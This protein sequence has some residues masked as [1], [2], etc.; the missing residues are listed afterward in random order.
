VVNM[1]V[2][3]MDSKK[4][5]SS[6]KTEWLQYI[7]TKYTPNPMNQQVDMFLRNKCLEWIHKTGNTKRDIT[8]KKVVHLY[9]NQ[10]MQLK[11]Y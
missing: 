9:F 5:G 3:E 6:S 7:E 2:P 1:K 10:K 11:K 4:I 8:L